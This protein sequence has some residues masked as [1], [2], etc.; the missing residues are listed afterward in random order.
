MMT[1]TIHL[2]SKSDR[3]RNA[4][5]DRLVSRHRTTDTHEAIS[6]AIVKH[7]GSTSYLWR[8]SGLTTGIYGQIVRPIGKPGDRSYTCVTGRIRIDIDAS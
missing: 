7:Y 4:D 5:I 1:V 6:R 2:L 8:D 3:P